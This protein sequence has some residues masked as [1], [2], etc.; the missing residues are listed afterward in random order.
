MTMRV[1][2]V[3]NKTDIT[4]LYFFVQFVSLFP[5]PRKVP[6]QQYRLIKQLA[7]TGIFITAA[8]LKWC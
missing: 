8:C 3:H 2:Y 1:C 5:L 4:R 7:T 6:A